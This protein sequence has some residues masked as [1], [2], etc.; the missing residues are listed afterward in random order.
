[1]F[2]SP[3]RS[4]FSLGAAVALA[5]ALAACS[6]DY[7]TGAACPDL[8]PTT[9]VEMRELVLDPIALDTT[10]VGLPPL[11]TPGRLLVATRG[12]TLVTYGVIRY[13]VLPTRYRPVP[14]DTATAPITNLID[15]EMRI[16][17]DS[18]RRIVTAPVTINL[19]DVDTTAADT[20]NAAIVALIR[21]DRLIGTVTLPQDTTLDTLRVPISNAVLLSKIQS[22]SRL[23]VGIQVTSDAGGIPQSAQFLVIGLASTTDATNITF[24]PVGED[25]VEGSEITIQPRSTTP[26][27]SRDA[28]AQLADYT[29]VAVGSPD[30]PPQEL[31][32][33]GMPSRRTYIR[34]DLPPEILDSA[35]IVRAQLILTQQPV[36]GG[37]L[38]DDTIGV[39]PYIVTAGAPVTDVERAASL[40]AAGSLLGL[41]SLKVVPS[42]S[43]V[44]TLEVVPLLRAW[45]SQDPERIPHAI[46]LRTSIEGYE[47]R[48]VRFH[49]SEAADPSLRPRL[50]LVYIP[51]T[52]QGLP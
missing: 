40:I 17:T 14:T 36:T 3:R 10:L 45:Q 34:F 21:P 39:Y 6:E 37:I 52:N 24:T 41:D 16:L 4:L 42:G 33:G 31:G 8:C 27:E 19:Y 23:R 48:E 26:E 1:M 49:S 22:E 46:V 51:R 43:A 38:P 30:P 25:A 18:V 15:A 11:G 5:A 47:P 7:G 32:V 2:D 50:R 35:T 29:V 12:D 9:N 44:G 28:A 20:S 13:D